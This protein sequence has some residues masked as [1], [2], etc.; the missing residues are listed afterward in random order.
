MTFYM[1]GTAVKSSY[2]RRPFIRS[3]TIN[4]GYLERRVFDKLSNSPLKQD[5]LTFD[6][7][8][9]TD[10]VY[11]TQCD[12]RGTAAASRQFLVCLLISTPKPPTASPSPCSSAP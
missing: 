8:F 2:H 12:S 10:L 9:T 11:M 3:K 7:F 5:V 6:A 1:N 4:C